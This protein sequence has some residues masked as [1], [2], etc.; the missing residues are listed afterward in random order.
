MGRKFQRRIE[1]FTCEHCGHQVKGSGFTNHCPVCLWSKHVD[2]NPGDREEG[3]QG[4]MEPVAVERHK[5]G[6][7]IRFRCTRCGIER[8]NKA[9][10]QDDFEMLLEIAKQSAEGLA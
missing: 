6:Y 5:D 9:A 10:P 4:L 1:D 3:C 2:I 7:R 8:W